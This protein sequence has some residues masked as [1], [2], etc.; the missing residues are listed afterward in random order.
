MVLTMTMA[1]D[2]LLYSAEP[3]IARSSSFSGAGKKTDWV[4]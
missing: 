4:L 2:T 3:F 1:E